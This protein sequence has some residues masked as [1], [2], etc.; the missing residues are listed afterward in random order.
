V[1]Y[2]RKLKCWF[3]LMQSRTA[4]ISSEFRGGFEHTK[5]LLGTPLA[6][7][8]LEGCIN[9]EWTKRPIIFHSSI[10][11]WHSALISRVQ[12]LIMGAFL[13]LCLDYIY[14]VFNEDL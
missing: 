2:K 5:P 7:D 13:V 1:N 8:G 12:Q 14:A 4:L 10:N 9:H 3:L 11:Q 6:L